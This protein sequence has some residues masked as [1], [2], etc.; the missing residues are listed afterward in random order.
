MKRICKIALGFLFL[1]SIFVSC[2]KDLP[3]F[4]SNES[5]LKFY[6]EKSADTLVNYSFA[7]G[8]ISEYTI[9]V[10][11]NLMGSPVD[12]DRPIELEQIMT[13]DKDAVPGEH[14]VPFNDPSLKGK[15]IMP[16]N[17]TQVEIPI[18]LKRGASLKQE[19]A[20]LK[21]T[22]KLNEVFS[23]KSREASMKQIH[24]SDQLVKPANWDNYVNHFLGNY[25]KSKHQFLIEQIPFKWD[26]DFINGEWHEYMRYDQNYLFYLNGVVREKYNAYKAE[27]GELM[28]DNGKPIEFP[29]N[30]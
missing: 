17:S 5:G 8:V 4:N 9:M 16:K 24:I 12:Y 1:C 3:V 18:I 11:V 26:D 29:N 13:G 20:N 28:D 21:F 30:N 22:F 7:Y 25:S 27:H 19:S 14:Y 6:F 23:Y 2:E 15:Y 10:K